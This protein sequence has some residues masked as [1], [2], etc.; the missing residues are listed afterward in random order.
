MREARNRA[1]NKLAAER[2]GCHG[3]SIKQEE[4]ERERDKDGEKVCE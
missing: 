3:L 2:K 1:Q 4:R